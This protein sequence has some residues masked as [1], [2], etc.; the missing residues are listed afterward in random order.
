MFEYSTMAVHQRVCTELLRMV[1]SEHDG[2]SF[3]IEPAPSHYQ[4]AT[5][6]STHREAVSKELA[7]LSRMGIVASG[8]R[9]IEVLDVERLRQLAQT[10]FS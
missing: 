8:R 6:L 7:R 10:S 1:D 3:M 4:I 9:K 5:M 2:N